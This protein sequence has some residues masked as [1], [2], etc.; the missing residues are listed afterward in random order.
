MCTEICDGRGGGDVSKIDRIELRLPELKKVG[1]DFVEK[2]DRVLPS[3]SAPDLSPFPRVT[4][5]GAV[6]GL[7]MGSSGCLG[8]TAPDLMDCC[9][10]AAS[11]FDLDR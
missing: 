7:S 3:L 10:L 11:F 8:P 5:P 2:P 4:L 6:R 9:C 1:G